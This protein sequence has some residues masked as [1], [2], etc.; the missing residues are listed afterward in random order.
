MAVIPDVTYGPKVAV[1]V[2]EVI[3][4]D[5][6]VITGTSAVLV[7]TAVKAQ[8]ALGWVPLG[9]VSGISTTLYAQAMVKY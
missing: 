2:I 7:A 8:M 5:Y 3:P 1:P 9:A 6:Q 4:S